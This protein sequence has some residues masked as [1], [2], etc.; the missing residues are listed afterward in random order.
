ML[1]SWKID[2]DFRM[3]GAMKEKG[4]NSFY[5]IPFMKDKFSWKRNSYQ[6]SICDVFPKKS[7]VISIE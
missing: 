7:Q 2:L 1:P 6:G 5:Q 3:K 4:K